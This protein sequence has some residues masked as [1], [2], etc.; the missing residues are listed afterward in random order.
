MT[1][2]TITT[3]TGAAAKMIATSL[4]LIVLAAC[5]ASDQSDIVPLVDIS[6]EQM[7]IASYDNESITK[8][9]DQLPVELV[10]VVSSAGSWGKLTSDMLNPVLANLTFISSSKNTLAYGYGTESTS[11]LSTSDYSIFTMA[12][13]SGNC[14][15]IKIVDGAGEPTIWRSTMFAPECRSDLYTNTDEHNWSA[16]WPAP[17]VPESSGSSTTLP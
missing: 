14:W 3:F 8:R 15:A 13:D 5:S 10:D 16:A 2:P 17:E 1:T 7:N 11:M 12:G 4:L 9:L 6:E